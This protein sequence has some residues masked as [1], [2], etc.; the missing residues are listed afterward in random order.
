MSKVFFKI[1]QTDYS[2]AVN[3][4]EYDVNTVPVYEAWT[5]VLWIEHRNYVRDRVQ[6]RF[7]L[8]YRSAAEFNA[9]ASAIRA[10]VASTG[11]ASCTVLSNSDGA[12]HTGDFYITI[13]GAAKWNLTNGRQ[14]Q[15][16][17]V[18]LYER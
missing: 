9:A 15:T 8:G 14:W 17:A 6:G 13:S 4:Q 12:L 2:E 5:D 18:D 7:E 1:G 16:L 3:I 10:A 11:Y